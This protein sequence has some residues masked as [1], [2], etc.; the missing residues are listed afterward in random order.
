[1]SKLTTTLVFWDTRDNA[2]EIPLT[3]F[4]INGRSPYILTKGKKILLLINRMNIIK[5]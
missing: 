3:C 1:M 4:T 5:E 2:I